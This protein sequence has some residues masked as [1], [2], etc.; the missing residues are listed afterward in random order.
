L[1]RES[2][3][4]SEVSSDGL[5]TL[6]LTDRNVY[7]VSP[8][9]TVIVAAGDKLEAG[10]PVCNAVLL[11]EFNRG[12]VPADLLG[13]SLGAGFLQGKYLGEVGFPNR[14]V[15]IKIETVGGATKVSCDLGG[16]PADVTT[17]WAETHARGIAR[18]KTLAQALDRRDTPEGQPQPDNLPTTINPLSLI[19]DSALRYNAFVV[20]ADVG[21]ATED[22]AGLWLLTT[23]ERLVPPHTALI[24]LLDAPRVTDDLS[25]GGA[26]DEIDSFDAADTYEHE[27]WDVEQ[28]VII[29]RVVSGFCQ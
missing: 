10:D 21:G 20:R 28:P 17:F 9:S 27:V 26:D 2:E 13:L 15:A 8:E 22:A 3:T 7:R 29:A 1:A 24:L 25:I 19:V 16:H 23:A 6:V 11:Y 14:D 4:V 5:H 12:Q 18:G